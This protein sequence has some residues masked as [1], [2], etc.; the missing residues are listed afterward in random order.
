M[1][2][3]PVIILAFALSAC[4]Q[5]SSA[6]KFSG[7]EKAVATVIEDL[8][9]NG[10]RRQADDVCDKLLTKSLQEKVAEGGKTCAAEMKKA[11]DDADAFDLEVEDVTVSGDQPTARVRGKD[12][13]DGI[14][15]TLE[16]EKGT[17]GWRIASFGSA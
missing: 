7:D 5:P 6:Q 2:A 9:R 13:D 3:L 14:L 4:G 16:L 11:L 8:Q 15:R 12:E 10:E 17:D 1:R